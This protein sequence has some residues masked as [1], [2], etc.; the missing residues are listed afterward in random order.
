VA[1]H[2]KFQ[3]LSNLIVKS[4][5]N[6]QPVRSDNYAPL[7]DQDLRAYLDTMYIYLD[8]EE[9]DRFA[10]ANFDQLI[11]QVQVLQS[12]YTANVVDVTLTFNHPVIELIW[13][14]RRKCMEMENNSFNYSG[15]DGR[16][17]IEGVVLLLNNQPRFQRRPGQY[18]RLVQPY[19]FHSSIPQSHVYVFSFALHPEEPQPTGSCNFSRID[20]A[21]LVFDLQPG[22]ETEQVTIIIFARNWQIMRFIEGV[23][24]ALFNA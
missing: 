5:A 21:H 9:R 24:G 10:T 8:M 17:P 14:C 7:A 22:L 18:F 20:N 4:S 16:D 11:T 1:I 13:A 19:Q 23:G 2:V 12:D 6:V 3:E 15:L